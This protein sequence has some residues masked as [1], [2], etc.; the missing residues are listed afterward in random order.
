MESISSKNNPKRDWYIWRDGKG[1]AAQPL[2]NCRS[3]SCL[4]KWEF[5]TEAKQYYA[6]TLEY[7]GEKLLFIAN[8]S[9]QPQSTEL[10]AV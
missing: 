10:F 2:N 7:E 5:D 1:N 9:E 3:Y 6:Y 8:F 4:S